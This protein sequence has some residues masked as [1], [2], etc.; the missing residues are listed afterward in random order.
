[1]RSVLSYLS[2]V[3]LLSCHP[4]AIEEQP[5][6]NCEG[7]AETVLTEVP[8]QL[9]TAVGRYLTLKVAVFKDGASI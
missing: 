7:K 8:A 3:V 6:C 2:L 5:G 4:Q 1:M 9:T